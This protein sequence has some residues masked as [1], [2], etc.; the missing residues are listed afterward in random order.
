MLGNPTLHSWK[1]PFPMKNSYMGRS[2]N[3]LALCKNRLSHIFYEIELWAPP[4]V[5]ISRQVVWYNQ[6][7]STSSNKV[8]VKIWIFS[9]SP[10]RAIF[11]LQKQAKSLDPAVTGLGMFLLFV[12]GRKIW[13]VLF[14]F[15]TIISVYKP[16]GISGRRKWWK[17]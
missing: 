4:Y 14:W 15:I 8:T 9:L 11:K 3:S 13:L 17:D 10:F 6:N 16:N 5:K 7:R 12:C 2:S 1:I